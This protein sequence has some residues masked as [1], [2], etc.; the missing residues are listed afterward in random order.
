M[1]KKNNIYFAYCDNFTKNIIENSFNRDH[2]QFIIK[3]Y[4]HLAHCNNLTTVL[5]TNKA[6]TEKNV[7]WNQ[8]GQITTMVMM[9]T[10]DF[11][12]G[13]IGLSVFSRSQM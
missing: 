4:T 8:N 11:C 2:Y 3:K 6:N 5:D 7:Q 10:C 12:P 1:R 9:F 13:V